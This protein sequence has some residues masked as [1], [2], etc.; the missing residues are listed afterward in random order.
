MTSVLEC[1]ELT[2]GYGG[3][4]VVRGINLHVEAGEVVA[5]LGPNG[6]G[7]TTTL[8]VLAGVL[9]A[10]EGSVTALGEAVRTRN[11]HLVARRGVALVPDDRAIFYGLSV[12]DNLRLGNRGRP[13]GSRAWKE[14]VEQV[15]DLFPALGPLMR[16]RA[17]LLSGGEQQMLAVARALVSKPKALMVD[18]MSLGL[19]PV[20][21]ERL[22]PTVRRIANEIEA[23]VLFV[24][25]HIDLALEVADRA[26]VLNHGDLVLE[27]RGKELLERRDLL[28]ASYMG[29]VT[30]ERLAG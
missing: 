6:A 11:P 26:Y 29:E 19:A 24:E 22:L 3:I 15:V 25:Q 16:R 17:G 23:G 12:A 1:H 30:F 10:I 27:G 9:P 5:L 28:E 20:V 8:L 4:P 7:K 13:G 18:E 2:A 21:V 14:H